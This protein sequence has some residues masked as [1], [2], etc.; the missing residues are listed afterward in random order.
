MGGAS[1][2]Y[3]WGKQP[4][5]REVIF[6]KDP[7]AAS[8]L[9][10]LRQQVIPENMLEE[11]ARS[12][13]EPHGAHA[14]RQSTSLNLRGEPERRREA[15][16]P[17]SLQSPGPPLNRGLWGDVRVSPHPGNVQGRPEKK[18]QTNHTRPWKRHLAGDRGK[19]VKATPLTLFWGS[20][21]GETYQK[22]T[23]ESITV[24]TEHDLHGQT[25]KRRTNLN[26][27]F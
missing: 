20:F 16:G 5:K 15:I 10:T 23:L 26:I 27:Q 1:H 18:G 9:G 19:R 24:L 14:G 22:D 3:C 2:R 6:G 21:G 8:E 25:G 7:A 11:E 17:N 12:S 4:R 13:W